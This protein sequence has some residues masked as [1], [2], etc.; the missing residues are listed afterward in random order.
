MK[1]F[2]S[3]A[4][5]LGIAA[6][7]VAKSSFAQPANHQLK[8]HI[9][10]IID[11]ADARVGVAIYGLDFK[12]SL[13]IN[14]NYHYPMQ[15]VFKFPLAIA[16]LERVD[17]HSMSMEQTVVVPRY[18]LDKKTH[19]PMLKD[20][21]GR[22]I[23]MPLS[24]MLMYSVSKSDNNACDALF[25]LMGG[26][27]PVNNYIHGIGIND[28]SIVATEWQMKANWAVQY[29]NWCQPSAMMKLLRGVYKRNYLSKRSTDY[30]LKIMTESE[31]PENR[32]KGQLP[33]GTIVAHKTGTSNENKQGVIAATNDVGIITLPDGRHYAIVVYV[34]DYKGGYD[35]GAAVIADIS[36]ATWD[37]FASK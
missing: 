25:H 32:L 17:R 26:T 19:S 13:F 33:E 30:L 35:K 28:I 18:Y 34:S 8:E 14:E 3:V 31:N 12:D 22:D 16:V 11:S 20:Y 23:S 21:P 2:R 15:S 29:T 1:N 10:Q 36:K 6:S 24:E 5:V 27:A 37:Y 4:L 7:L 9:L